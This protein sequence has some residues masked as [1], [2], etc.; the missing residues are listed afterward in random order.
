MSTYKCRHLKGGK[1]P[2]KE[3]E[4][5][6]NQSYGPP[7]DVGQFKLVDQ[8]ETTRTYW[9]G[10]QCVFVIRGTNP[11]VVDWY[12]NLSYLS[13]AYKGTPRFKEALAAYNKAVVD[14]GEATISVLGHSQGGGSA[15][16]FPNA[17]EII[18]LNRAYKGE[19]IP[20]N[21]YDIHATLDPVSVLLNAR[22]PP[23]DIP[24]KSK[25]FNPLTNHSIDILKLLDPER[26]VG[27]GRDNGLTDLE[28]EALCR[29]FK[30]PLVGVYE[31]S[32]LTSL[33]YGNFLINLNGQSHWVAMCIGKNNFYYDSYGFPAPEN[34]QNLM[35]NYTWSD[36]QIQDIN[37]T[38]CGYFC[39]AFLKHM[40][41][42]NKQMY[43]AFCDLFS[44]PKRNDKILFTL[45]A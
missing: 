45:L 37:S 15:S 10:T 20:P 8:T 36:T 16:F 5:F 33:P 40:Q 25:S 9:N 4:D 28:L 13:G 18:T 29:H 30:I 12:N 23:N 26:M 6:L 19:S 7:S 17:H 27:G 34:L 1:L 32:E 3:I 21:E 44:S 24:I 39:V 42:P 38:A 41:P 22:K 14:Y 31:K 43:D 2:V 11:T 35:G